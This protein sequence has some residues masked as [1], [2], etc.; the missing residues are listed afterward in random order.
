MNSNQNGETVEDT[1][2]YRSVMMQ[3]LA[4]PSLPRS[5]ANY[6]PT[7]KVQPRTQIKEPT[8]SPS[9][10]KVAELPALPAEYILGRTNVYVE[11]TS[12]EVASRICDCLRLESTAATFDEDDK[13]RPQRRR[14]KQAFS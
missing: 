6:R 3:P 10:W 14:L 1:P 5:F 13:V 12:Q 9:V 2:Q 4:A 8:I 7:S 11:S